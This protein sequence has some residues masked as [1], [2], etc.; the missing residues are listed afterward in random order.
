M[1]AGAPANTLP[2]VR[3]LLLAL[4]LLVLALAPSTS[5]AELPG[6]TPVSCSC[7]HALSIDL[8]DT[9]RGFL[10]TD[11]GVNRTDDGGWT[12]KP[13][14]FPVSGEVRRVSFA[15]RDNGAVVG[16]FE[17]VVVTRDG[18]T[19]WTQ[20]RP[21]PGRS[22]DVVA[23]PEGWFGLAESGLYTSTDT[24]RVWTKV[25]DAFAPV[26]SFTRMSWSDKDT[27]VVSNG[28]YTFTTTDGGRTFTQAATRSVFAFDALSLGPGEAAVGGQRSVHSGIPWVGHVE[29]S[30]HAL[31]PFTTRGVAEEQVHGVA[32]SGSTYYAVGVEGLLARSTDAGASWSYEKTPPSY[33]RSSFYDVD[34]LDADHA[35]VA[36]W[37]GRVLLRQAP[38]IHDVTTAPHRGL[39]LGLGGLALVAAGAGTWALVTR[40]PRVVAGALAGV[41][42]AAGVPGTLLAIDTRTCHPGGCG[43]VTVGSGADEGLVPPPTATVSATPSP[44]ASPTPSPTASPTPSPTPSPTASPT[45]LGAFTV[46]PVSVESYCTQQGN[47]FVPGTVKL[48][49]RNGTALPVDWTAEAAADQ[50]NRLQAWAN[51]QPGS[52]Q[53]LPTRSAIVRVTPN[54]LYCNPQLEPSGHTVTVTHGDGQTIVTI[55]VYP[56]T[57]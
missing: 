13:L 47:R 30:R 46:T 49:L 21:W 55:T 51:V 5:A 41:T 35:V 42:L 48:T 31:Y 12:W 53:L 10:G 15:D 50:Q 56:P 7:G 29:A 9:D 6:W 3:R 18:G 32:R 37:S 24:G 38:T 36:V 14:P 2:V 25:H 33:E 43:T 57:G 11:A 54:E 45:P 19:T 23:L 1:A 8:V 44:T 22:L 16:S 28:A 4:S 17:G 34:T 20:Y 27:G 52:G 39:G 40:R 26:V